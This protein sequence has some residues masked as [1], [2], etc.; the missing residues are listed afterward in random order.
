MLS[1]SYQETTI[2]AFASELLP[3]NHGQ[4][5]HAALCFPF[6]P[7]EETCS[8][9]WPD[10]AHPSALWVPR[11]ATSVPLLRLLL[12][13]VIP[14]PHSPHIKS[15]HPS[16]S[17]QLLLSPRKPTGATTANSHPLVFSLTWG[18]TITYLV[19]YWSLF[20]KIGFILI[21]TVLGLQ[22]N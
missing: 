6:S 9:C 20:L 10:P 5:L 16:T 15:H 22:Q 2:K 21:I 17:I 7:A 3:E 12:L 11:Q 8:S 1:V 19:S 13:P 18:T 14:P 4:R